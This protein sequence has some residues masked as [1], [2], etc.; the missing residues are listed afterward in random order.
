MVLGKIS[1]FIHLKV[2]CSKILCVGFSKSQYLILLSIFLYMVRIKSYLFVNTNIEMSCLNLNN[3]RIINCNQNSGS[4]IEEF[5]GSE[6]TVDKFSGSSSQVCH[7]NINLL[8]GLE[9]SFQK[10]YTF[11]PFLPFVFEIELLE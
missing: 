1:I 7:S 2:D 9:E 11:V 10:M 5:Y 8:I 3:S 6:I 4:K